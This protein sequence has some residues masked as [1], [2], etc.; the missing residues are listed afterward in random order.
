MG[1]VHSNC[2]GPQGDENVVTHF[3]V[4]RWISENVHVCQ[5]GVFVTGKPSCF[6]T[7]VL[8]IPTLCEAGDALLPLAGLCGRG[9]LPASRKELKAV[10]QSAAEFPMLLPGWFNG[11]LAVLRIKL[12]GRS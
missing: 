4:L 6:H 12:S 10:S 8:W 7:W 5:S 3:A 9:I 2:L 1:L 11:L